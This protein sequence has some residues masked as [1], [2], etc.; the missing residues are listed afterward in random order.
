MSDKNIYRILFIGLFLTAGA[1]S[2]YLLITIAACLC[3]SRVPR[4]HKRE[5]VSSI[6]LLLFYQLP[7]LIALLV[8][9]LI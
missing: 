4:P 3:R 1:L 7:A 8:A 2:W 9:T 6:P 5:L